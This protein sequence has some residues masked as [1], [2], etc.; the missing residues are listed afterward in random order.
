MI[1]FLLACAASHV[2]VQA[3]VPA[4]APLMAPL[5]AAPREP[6]SLWSAETARLLVG[7]DHYRAVGDAVTVVI[8]ESTI[9]QLNAG[10]SAGRESGAGFAIDALLGLETS[11]TKA[12]KPMG[13]K[14]GLE[15]SSSSSLNGEGTTS[16][17]GSVQAVITCQVLQV[18]SNGM[19]LLEG[20]KS[21]TVNN[22]TQIVTL[23]GAARTRDISADNTLES[24]RLLNA[25][26]EITGNGV[27]ANQQHQGWGTTVANAI[28]PF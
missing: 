8:D 4:A 23:R 28:W 5:P 27:L 16:R 11:I 12:N 18:A 25:Q 2:A 19:L 13:G 7:D 21:V 17:N 6:G 14:I 15:G 20:Q 1:L 26:V 22:E 10:T 3:P 9:T 24:F